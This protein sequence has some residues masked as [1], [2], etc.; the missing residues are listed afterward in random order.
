MSFDSHAIDLDLSKSSMIKKRTRPQPRVRE[1]S[2][3]A[4]EASN[5]S[6]GEKGEEEKLE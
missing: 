4:E 6:A 2:P 1:I 3:E 5:N